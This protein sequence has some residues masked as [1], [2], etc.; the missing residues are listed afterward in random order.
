M[1]TPRFTCAAGLRRMLIE[2][3]RCP[4]GW[5][6]PEAQELLSH[7]AERY[8][9]L[10]RKYGQTG[11]DAA[12]TAYEALTAPAT[13]WARDPWG[14]VTQAVQRTLQAEHRAN[15]LLCGVEQA[16]HLMHE[17]LF[18]AK[19]FAEHVS[20]ERELTACGAHVEDS[21]ETTI[22][23]EPVSARFVPTAS[24]LADAVRVFSFCGWPADV[25][26]GALELI[27]SRLV[28]A[29][30]RRRA[31]EYLR[32]HREGWAHL[33]LSQEQW[34]R[35]LTVV[36]GAPNPDLAATDLGRG[37]LW[38]LVVGQSREEICCDTRVTRA[39]ARSAPLCLEV[40]HA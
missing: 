31:F 26:W 1:S 38:R 35:V 28:E 21:L 12:T 34:T 37:L 4:A 40:R 18:D 5:D 2:L 30:Q 6:G 9:G 24:A 19:R 25:A 32:R 23:V 3:H 20:V 29:G 14:V 17:P 27:C 39:L 10:A 11:E 36:L 33:D 16:R 13:R 8:R 15:G 22:G 7:C